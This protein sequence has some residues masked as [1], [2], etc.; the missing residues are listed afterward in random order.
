MG[1]II[2][3][4]KV[5][6]SSKVNGRLE[7]IYLREGDTVKK[8][9]LI[10]E[11]EKLPLKIQ[12]QQQ[13]SELNIAKKSYDL[14]K[15]KYENAL[16]AIE[17]KLKTIAKAKADLNDKKVTYKNMERVLKN[18]KILY[19]AGGLSESEL[20][21]VKT[22]HT[23]LYTKYQLAITDYEIQQIGYRDEDIKAEDYKVPKSPKERKKILK[24]INTKIEWAELQASKARVSQARNNLKS[25]EIMLNETY[26]RSP[27]FGLVAA[28]NMEAGE[29][30]KPDSTIATLINISDVYI[31]MNV[32][33][34]DVTRI[35]KG[36]PVTFTVDAIG[37]KEFKAKINRIT[38]VLDMKTR[39]VEVKAV[40]KNFNNKL[41]PGMFA[42]AQIE[43]GNLGSK[44]VI[45]SSAIIKKDNKK[46]EIY[47]VKKGLLFKQKIT[48]GEEYGK[49]VEI[50]DGLKIGDKIISKGVNIV[51]PGMELKEN[52]N[53]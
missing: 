7:K 17:I 13:K 21:G 5:T 2:F 35:K 10:A 18:K 42:R 15:A 46:A 44:L 6:I 36:Q 3:K 9:Q 24:K 48:L 41:L 33:E 39:T 51:F 1:Q 19:E 14:T 50:I 12:L 26:I 28:R 43:T 8:G 22:Q 30:I 49:N 34:K 38:P 40:L 11:V 37:E 47:I 20:E 31:A 4:E 32:N 16:K 29:M 27:I 53:K 45:P 23:T 52:K 25:T